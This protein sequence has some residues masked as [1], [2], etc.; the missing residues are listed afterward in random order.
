MGVVFTLAQLRRGI[1]AAVFSNCVSRL[2]KTSCPGGRLY[3][4]NFP[5]V[6]GSA[7]SANLLGQSWL[8]ARGVGRIVGSEAFMSDEAKPEGNSVGWKLVTATTRT[9]SQSDLRRLACGRGRRIVSP[10]RQIHH[11]TLKT[12]AIFDA[13]LSA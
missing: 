10:Q 3:L 7:W 8:S 12:E 11:R 4:C 13:I 5:R 2:T 1:M 6:T 9:V